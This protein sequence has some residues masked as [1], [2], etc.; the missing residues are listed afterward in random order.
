M[1]V[2]KIAYAACAAALAAGAAL[3][4]AAQDFTP[5][6]K[7]VFIVAGR[8]T[9]VLPDEAGDIKTA[10]GV[11][12]GLDVKVSDDTVPTLG[13]TYFVTDN[14]AIEAILGASNHEINAVGGATNVRVHET[15]VLPPVVTLQYHFA[16]AAKVSPYVGAGVN[17][18]IFFSGEDKN[19]FS[20]DLDNGLGYALQAGVD[21][22]VSGPWSVNLDVKKVFF[23][24]DA[25]INNGALKADVDLDPL[26]VSAG[27]ARRF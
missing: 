1:Q 24:T 18:M 20:V 14:V 5:K 17:A 12:S 19:G 3:P 25:K 22:A 6:Q 7:G 21:I 10:A 11:D 13:F 9:G 15:W 8:V 27:L 4:A 2:N 23:S 26:V 16:P